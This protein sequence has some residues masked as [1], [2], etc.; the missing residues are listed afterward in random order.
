MTYQDALKARARIAYNSV[1]FTKKAADDQSMD[2]LIKRLE[3]AGGDPTAAGIDW[4]TYQAIQHEYENRWRKADAEERAA[5]EART[6]DYNDTMARI[7]RKHDTIEAQHGINQLSAENPGAANFSIPLDK[8][9]EGFA[10]AQDNAKDIQEAVG[11]APR[12]AGIGV[13]AGVL[14]GLGVGAGAYGLMGLF[15]SLRKRRLLRALI[16]LGAGGAAGAG[17]G[18]AT[19]KGLNTAA[20]NKAMNSISDRVSK[21]HQQNG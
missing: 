7:G 12:N 11:K 8:M 15:P 17:I 4:P 1:G 10:V 3:T 16:A 13:G 9:P 14:G 20:A 6:K 18:L 19:T 5:G 2:M 21:F